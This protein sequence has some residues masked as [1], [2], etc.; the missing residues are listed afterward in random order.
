LSE[1]AGNVMEKAHLVW[2]TPTSSA[3]LLHSAVERH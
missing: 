2:K 3:T 1:S